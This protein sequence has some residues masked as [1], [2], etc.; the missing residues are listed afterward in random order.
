MKLFGAKVLHFRTGKYI[1]F[2]GEQIHLLTKDNND[3]VLKEIQPESAHHLKKSASL[4]LLGHPYVKSFVHE[5]IHLK[6]KELSSADRYVLSFSPVPKNLRSVRSFQINSNKSITIHS[7]LSQKGLKL[8]SKYKIKKNWQPLICD[9]V[10]QIYK[11]HKNQI[12]NGVS[13]LNLVLNSEMLSA[14]FQPGFSISYFA[15]FKSP[16]TDL[17]SKIYFFDHFLSD[18]KVTTSITDFTQTKTLNLFQDEHCDHQI[19]YHILSM[20]KKLQRIISVHLPFNVSGFSLKKFVNLRIALAMCLVLLSLWSFQEYRVLDQLKAEKT[21]LET[22][23]EALNQYLNHLARFSKHERQYFKLLALNKAIKQVSL[24]PEVVLSKL[25]Q[26][27][28][29]TVWLIH[30]S[31]SAEKIKL[32]LL[33]REKTEVTSLLDLFDAN[34]GQSSLVSNEKSKLNAFPVNRITIL[35]DQK[36]DETSVN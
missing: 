28:P 16:E 31:I 25:D 29:K 9:L 5:T 11:Y 21:E 2:H 33:D 19:L 12:A 6:K 18:P 8:I 34:I 35:I 32:V 24:K 3:V 17:K 13:K 10:F 1:L 36:K 4:F 30:Y 14:N 23:M 20:R 22:K 26:I 15:A 27:L 7:H